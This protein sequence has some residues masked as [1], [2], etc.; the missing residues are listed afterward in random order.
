M[1]QN[2]ILRSIALTL[3]LSGILL[4]QNSCEEVAPPILGESFLVDSTYLDLDLPDVQ[5][6]VVLLEDFTGVQCVQCPK[7]HELAADLLEVYP[8]QMAVVAIHN[9]F[10]GG[11]PNSDED[12]RIQE[13]FD[14]NELLGPTTLWPAGAI[15]RHVFDSEAAVLL[16][17]S[18]WSGYMAE[19]VA[20]EAPVHIELEYNLTQNQNVLE[21]LVKAHFLEDIE[22]DVRLSLMLTEG[23]IVDPQLTGDGIIDDYIHDHVLRDM[24][25]PSTGSS[26][27]FSEKGRVI[28]RGYAMPLEDHWQKDHLEVVAFVHRGE[29]ANLDVLQTAKLYVE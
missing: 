29:G 19:E 15:D 1:P 20:Q 22:G 23:A 5:Q 6:K 16:E 2:L 28:I 13:A 11:Y 18:K 25:T 3:L 21:V 9:Y 7:A 27:D 24:A 10:V 14:L 4:L 8:D 12:F 17:T 26:L